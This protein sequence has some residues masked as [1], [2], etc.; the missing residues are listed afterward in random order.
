MTPTISTLG[1]L[2]VLRPD[3]ERPATRAS[4]V[5]R[6]GMADEPVFQRGWLHLAEHWALGP[7]AGAADYVN[8]ATSTH[9]LRFELASA[10]ERLP[11]ALDQLTARLINPELDGIDHDLTILGHER[12]SRNPHWYAT[13]LAHRYGVAGPGATMLDE[14]GVERVDPGALR[15]WLGRFL[16]AENAVLCLNGRLAGP[17]AVDLPSGTPQPPW[18]GWRAPTPAARG[19]DEHLFVSAETPPGHP[20]ALTRQVVGLHLARLLRAAI[21]GPPNLGLA[22]GALQ[23]DADVWAASWPASYCQRVDL[24]AVVRLLDDLAAGELDPKLATAAR[25]QLRVRRHL[26]DPDALEH[27]V[28][29]AE[30]W[31][32]TGREPDFEPAEPTDAELAE[33]LVRLRQTLLVSVPIGAEPPAT[34]PLFD[35]RPGQG[36]PIARWRRAPAWPGS[37]TLELLADAFRVMVDDQPPATFGFGEIVGVRA[38]ADGLLQIVERQAMMAQIDPVRWVGGTEAVQQLLARIQPQLVHW[39]PAREFSQIPRP[40]AKPS[41]LERFRN[42]VLPRWLAEDR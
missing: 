11:G 36:Q 25:D 22:N 10:A 7:L 42:E 1:R 26:A 30:Y 31:L 38:T 23:P 6:V 3:V 12:R 9:F 29:Q 17:L 5:F 15:A 41:V 35:P 13:M 32:Q 24:E 16:V 33:A 27:L 19:L 14:L 39:L 18:V 4:L 2:R 20:G 21:G 28:D 8:G 37:G 40:P 34:L